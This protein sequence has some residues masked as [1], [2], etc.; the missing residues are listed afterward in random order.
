MI[1]LPS[2]ALDEVRAEE[3]RCMQRDGRSTNDFF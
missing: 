2:G 1:N 3:T